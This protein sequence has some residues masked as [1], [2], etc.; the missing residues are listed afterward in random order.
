MSEVGTIVLAGHVEMGD[1]RRGVFATVGEL[2]M[3]DPLYLTQHDDERIYQVTEI[4]QVAPDDL[5]V[6]YPAPE[7]KLTLITC[8]DYDFVQNVY[9]QR[10]IVVAERVT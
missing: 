1:G 9:L 3:G 5:T 10:L 2:K 4:R 7:D 8:T 6:L